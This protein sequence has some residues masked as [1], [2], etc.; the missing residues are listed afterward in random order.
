MDSEQSVARRRPR[1]TRR[2][3]TVGL[4][5]AL[6]G[7]VGAAMLWTAVGPASAATNQPV[8]SASSGR[9]LDVPNAATAN[10][11]LVT[12]WDCNG[13]ANQSWT[14]TSSGQL[15]VYGNKC[16]DAATGGDSD[17]DRVQIMDCTGGTA[18]R[19]TFNSNGTL[20]NAVTGRCLDLSGGA[21]ANGSIVLLWTCH[22]GT[23]QRWAQTGGGTTPTTPGVTTPPVTGGGGC[24]AAPVN[25]NASPQARRLLCF[26]QSQYGNHIISG[27]QE[28][29]WI[30]GPEH[31]MNHIRNTTGKLPA[32]R[33]LDF[34]DSHESLT[35]R[36][37]AWWNAGGI[38]MVG[39]H[40]G[41]PT[42]PDTYAG[43]METV[44]INRVLT[45]GT[46][47][48]TS[49]IQRLD[50]VSASLQQMENA[51][52]A[53]IWRPY[54]EAGGTWFW[55]SK[56]GGAQYNRL[57]NF[58]YNYMTNTKGLNNLIWLHG[59]N[60]QPQSSFYPGKATVDIGGA[61][62]YAGDGNYGPLTSM[63]NSVR[64]IVGTSLPIALHENGP[65]P[66]P[67]QLQSAG[68]RWVLFAT[69]HGNHLTVSNSAAHLR[70]VFNHA[71]VVTRDEVP[72]LR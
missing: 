70:H 1:R 72:N 51:N 5:V 44:S 16:L 14:T 12:I 36:A 49:F 13:G 63:Y 45:P 69:W 7:S 64:N 38:P 39:Y 43:T 71:Y 31:E 54:H 41:A 58:T 48:Y 34:G 67:N 66:D 33:G 22:G 9:C 62:T 21:T 42:R 10:G 20:S 3:A 23:N 8:V 32:I 55:W 47:E 26:I 68:S 37:I 52:V 46:A 60:G 61:D 19:W 18:Q 2:L 4:V 59:Y 17:G 40:M 28:S 15:T 24:G 30:G 27:Q 56:E 65:I 29:T 57:W 6:A 53:V 25:P 35:P 11:T 50:Q